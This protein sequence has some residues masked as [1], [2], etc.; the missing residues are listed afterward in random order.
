VFSCSGCFSSAGSS[1]QATS[2]IVLIAIKRA[3]NS[4]LMRVRKCFMVE[5]SLGILK[6]AGA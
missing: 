2:V 3:S 1:A 6:Y 4:A 5:T